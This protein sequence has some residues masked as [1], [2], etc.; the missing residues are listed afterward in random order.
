MNPQT[1]IELI[2]AWVVLKQ[3]QDDL[4]QRLRNIEELIGEEMDRRGA[5]QLLVDGITVSYTRKSVP[6]HTMLQ[7][8]KEY[9][10]EKELIDNGTYIPAH[11][12]TITR[13]VPAKWDMQKAKKNYLG[14]KAPSNEVVEVIRKAY[15]IHDPVLKITEIKGEEAK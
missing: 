8:L 13:S 4:R 7:P 1:M 15:V 9:I 10:D 2:H 6:E 11:E 14:D 12:E 5:K 3:E